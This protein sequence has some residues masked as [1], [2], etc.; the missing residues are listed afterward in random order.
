[1]QRGSHL[2]QAGL[3]ILTIFTL[4]YTVIP[5][6]QTA[7]LQEAIARQEKELEALRA[8]AAQNYHE[9]RQRM[10]RMLAHTAMPDCTGL[11]EPMPAINDPER[12]KRTGVFMRSD[13]SEC[14]RERIVGSPT[15]SNLRPLDRLILKESLDKALDGI[16]ASQQRARQA[17]AEAERLPDDQLP[18]ARP[19]L[20]RLLRAIGA[21]EQQISKQIR[22][23]RVHRRQ[24]EIEST[25]RTE[26]QNHVKALADEKLYE[27]SPD[28]G[29]YRGK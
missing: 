13:V 12:R 16:R 9:Q 19:E 8:Q 21:G 26:V 5:L 17:Y 4:F 25:F 1:L 27:Q 14:V 7:G 20:E 11:M 22:E 24:L 29:L 28:T 15:L 23:N 6:Y 10:L 18:P 3:F 2:A